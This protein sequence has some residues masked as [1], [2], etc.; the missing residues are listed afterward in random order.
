[1]TQVQTQQF[2]TA[3]K[4]N[5]EYAIRVAQA[6]EP[7]K[8]VDLFREIGLEV[9]S[10]EAAQYLAEAK[11]QLETTELSEE[12]LETVNGGSL[13]IGYLLGCAAFG[14]VAG[15]VLGL[16]VVGIYCAYK[17]YMR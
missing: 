3:I 15:V 5:E 6:N 14:A 9:T 8:L 4:E 7:E 12:M 10:E 16:V 2:L 17:K 1:M 11:S 13:T